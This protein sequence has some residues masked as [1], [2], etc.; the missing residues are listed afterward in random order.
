MKLAS[1]LS[2]SSI[3]IFVDFNLE[4]TCLDYEFND[5]EMEIDC[6]GDLSPWGVLPSLDLKLGY[7]TLNDTNYSFF[8][9]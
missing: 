7:L 8:S 2:R 9:L 5:S 1:C 4:V 6:L 3:S